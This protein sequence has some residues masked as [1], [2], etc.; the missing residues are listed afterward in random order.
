MFLWLC[1]LWDQRQG[2]Q[3]TVGSPVGRRVT[4]RVPDAEDQGLCLK[5]IPGDRM[6]FCHSL[7]M[8]GT[9]CVCEG[10]HGHLQPT[11]CVYLPCSGFS[12]F[13]PIVA[14]FPFLA[15]YLHPV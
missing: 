10:V 11:G 4:P 3:E 2:S 12:L 9:G 13:P 1:W 15:K 7:L 8:L 14:L 6:D 5:I